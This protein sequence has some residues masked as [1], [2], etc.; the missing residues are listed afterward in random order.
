MDTL[1]EKILSN[2]GQWNDTHKIIEIPRAEEAL[3]RKEVT[4]HLKF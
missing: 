1:V 2:V 3:I 4:R